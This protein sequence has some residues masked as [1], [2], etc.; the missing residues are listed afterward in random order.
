MLGG[1]LNDGDAVLIDYQV[2]PHRREHD[3]P[4]PTGPSAGGTILIRGQAKGLVVVCPILRINVS[5]LIRMFDDER[6]HTELIYRHG[7][8]SEYRVWK[9][10]F[11]LEEEFYDST[12]YPYDATRFFSRMTRIGFLRT[13]TGRRESELLGVVLSGHGQHTEDSDAVVAG[14]TPVFARAVGVCHVIGR[15]RM[16][17]S[18]GRPCAG[19]RAGIELDSSADDGVP[20][21]AQLVSGDSD[22]QDVSFQVVRAGIRREF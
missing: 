10:T 9:L 21:V 13:R 5:R 3:R 15:T 7:H 14:L 22:F 16:T 11:G 2:E 4:R 1:R 19:G 18:G 17:S 8:R 12:L 6:P 20:D